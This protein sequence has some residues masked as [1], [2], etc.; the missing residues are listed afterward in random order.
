VY[1]P[2]LLFIHGSW[3][4]LSPQQRQ[5][6]SLKGLA[7]HIYDTPSHQGKKL[8]P[9]AQSPFEDGTEKIPCPKECGRVFTTYQQACHHAKKK[10]T[11]KS[12]NGG[13]EGC[14][15][16]DATNIPCA[17]LP[18]L[19]CTH[20]P[21][22]NATSHANHYRSHVDDAN[23][24]YECSKDCG[25]HH[26]CLCMLARR[27]EKC[28]GEG[29]VLRE[30]SIRFLLTKESPAPPVV[31]LVARASSSPPKCWKAGK[32]SSREG[33]PVWG[34]QVLSHFAVINGGLPGPAV[35]HVCSNVRTRDLPAHDRDDS[36]ESETEARQWAINR[37]HKFTKVVGEV[38]RAASKTEV[39][40]ILLSI[41]LCE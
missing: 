41:G 4:G 37:A 5:F 27:E 31:I 23:G 35:L 19:Q 33:L 24:P 12:K 30:T 20:P 1:A 21:S 3:T 8:T 13:N 29:A 38:L 15:G 7:L 25:E 11:T 34:R 17:W 40:P 9:F 26:A 10:Q 16:P 6:G 32:D 36:H 14:L 18:Y 2:L 22:Y 28:T 39:I